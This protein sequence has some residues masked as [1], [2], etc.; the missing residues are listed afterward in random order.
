MSSMV[1]RIASRAFARGLFDR[2]A[3]AVAAWQRRNHGHVSAVWVRIEEDVVLRS[4][5]VESLS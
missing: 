3:L 5:H 1:R 2:L 4:G